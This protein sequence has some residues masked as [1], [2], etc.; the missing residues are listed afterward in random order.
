MRFFLLDAQ[1]YRRPAGSSDRRFIRTLATTGGIEVTYNGG[2]A[3]WVNISYNI[4]D[5]LIRVLGINGTENRVKV[6]RHTQ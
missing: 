3:T 5:I 2:A 6:A 4:G 1:V